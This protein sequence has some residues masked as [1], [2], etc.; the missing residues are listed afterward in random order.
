MRVQNTIN[1]QII[2]AELEYITQQNVFLVGGIQAMEAA[3]GRLFQFQEEEVNDHDDN[4]F[5]TEEEFI[6]SIA[7]M[8]LERPR[9]TG[10][11]SLP[12]LSVTVSSYL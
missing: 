5:S 7:I 12:L 4:D 1:Q 6:D 10:Q 8:L 9:I 3:F 11:T 2:N